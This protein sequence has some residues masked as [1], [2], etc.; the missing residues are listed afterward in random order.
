MIDQEK[1]TN[2]ACPLNVT[3]L[4]DYLWE[5]NLCKSQKTKKKTNKP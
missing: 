3:N 4:A 1:K 5:H 2:K